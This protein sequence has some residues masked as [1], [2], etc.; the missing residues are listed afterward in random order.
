MAMLVKNKQMGLLFASS[1][2]ILFT[3][4]GLFPILPL[5][6]AQF[7]AT[8][9]LIGMYYAIMYAANALGP[10][11]AGWLITRFSKR[12]VFIAGGVVGLP[13]LV[14]LGAAQHFW[15]VVVLTSLVWFAGG[16]VLAL[17]SILAGLHS[18][19]NNR[20]KA[21]SLLA[22]VGPVSAL[23]GGAVVGRLVGWQGYAVMFGALAAV[24]L[25]VPLIGWLWLK[26]PGARNAPAG[27]GREASNQSAA[28]SAPGAA[29]FRLLAIVFVGAMA[30]NVSRLGTSLV[31]QSLDFSPE[32]VSSVA[33][34][35]GLVAI[36]MTLA[37]GGLADRL[38]SR[39]FL[40]IS[41]LFTVSGALILLSASALWQFWL[42]ASLF[43]LAFSVSG[44]MGQAMTSQ[45]VPAPALS[46]SLSWLNTLSA[47]ASIVIFAAGGL[48]FDLL[49]MP[50]VF[51]MA[52]LMALAAGG[53]LELLFHTK[54][55][56]PVT[57][58]CPEA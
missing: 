8:N 48:L 12:A 23:A 5:F 3:G 10:V 54:R 15:Q 43:M 33:M 2:A 45:I 50:P 40:F 18:E 58:D 22:M 56:E 17:V 38:G 37:I 35:S 14:L 52:A 26:E 1:F 25:A 47:A 49:G 29:F 34:I 31:M 7:G 51:L 30:V 53:A 28:A 19:A 55:R 41:Y 13:A 6:A 44:A 39:H 11:A 20:G 9:S 21:F 42:A 16:L 24:W 46:A 4:M 27:S 57:A 36:P 32:A